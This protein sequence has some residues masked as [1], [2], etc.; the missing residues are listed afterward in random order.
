MQR[1]RQTDHL[2][3]DRACPPGAL[4]TGSCVAFSLSFTQVGYSSGDE[5]EE[6]AEGE[7]RHTLDPSEAGHT[8]QVAPSG[9]VRESHGTMLGPDEAAL[10]ASDDSD[11]VGA[12]RVLVAWVCCAGVRVCRCADVCRCVRAAQSCVHVS[13]P[14]HQ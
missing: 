5:P 1:A 9:A 4:A 10:I 6:G 14:K 2:W 8:Y 7:P 3:C 13:C 12:V 11:K